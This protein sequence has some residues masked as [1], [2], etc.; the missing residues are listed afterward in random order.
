MLL[1]DTKHV[2]LW[3]YNMKKIQYGHIAQ[4]NIVSFA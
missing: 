2:F 1:M 4:I 3:S